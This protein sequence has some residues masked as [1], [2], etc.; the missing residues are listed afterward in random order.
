MRVIGGLLAV[1]TAVVVAVAPASAAP[2]RDTLLRPGVGAGKLRLGMTF[3]QVKAA[4]GKP[5][6]GRR[7]RPYR[8]P[9]PGAYFEYEWGVEV[10]WKVGVY[11]RGDSGRVVVI[12]TPRRERTADGVGVGSTEAAL[13]RAL[14][15]RCYL[16]PKSPL[17]GAEEIPG[18]PLTKTCYHGGSGHGV[19]VGSRGKPVT[20]F[21]MFARCSMP[22]DRYIVCPK[23]KRTYIAESVW[24]ADATG[25]RIWSVIEERG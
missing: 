16:P 21:R 10:A 13:K 15:V 23:S 19:R 4:I 2:E 22:S 11:G 25:Q 24:I 5:D 8:N 17:P 3:A 6:R 9:I 1:V 14:G 12:E 20:L 18:Y 7:V